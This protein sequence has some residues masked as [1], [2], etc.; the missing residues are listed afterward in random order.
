MDDVVSSY[1]K[2]KTFFDTEY[3]PKTRAT[4]GAS[5][6]PDGLAF[7][8]D[9][10]NHYT[11]TKLSYEEVYQLGL[12]EVERIQAEMMAILKELKYKGTMR[13]FIQFL[14]TNP[15]FYVTTGDQVVEGG[16]MDRKEIR[17]AASNALRKIAPT[18]LW[19][20]TCAGI[21]RPHLHGGSILRRKHS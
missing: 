21:P 1:K 9:R 17:G 20:C 7:Y 6:F 16:I 5:H 12:K 4:L 2:I 18:T 15:K 14:R 11:T 10:V 13:E 8:Q 19:C 3:L